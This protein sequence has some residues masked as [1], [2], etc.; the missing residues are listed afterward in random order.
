M[1]LVTKI[2][3][4]LL[5]LL[6]S[7]NQ[8]AQKQ[9]NYKNEKQLLK[10]WQLK[11]TVLEKGNGSE[12]SSGTYSK[13]KWFTAEVPTTVLGALVKNKVYPNP[14]L[15]VNNYLIPDI[16][17]QFNEEHDLAKYSYLPGNVNPWKD[18]YWF[19]TEFLVP[20]ENAGKQVWLNFDGINYR[21]EVWLNGKLVADKEEMAGTFR[22][23]KFNITDKVKSGIKNILAVKIYPVG[24]PGKPGTQFKVFGGNRGP[25]Q[26]LFKDV[27]LKISGGWDCALPVRDRN[28]GIYQDVYLTYTEEVDIIN[29]YIIT[30]LLL[31]D[32]TTADLTIRTTLYNTSDKI[33]KGSLKGKINLLTEIDMVHYVKKVD[34][35][36]DEISFE[37][38]VVVPANDTVTVTLSFND[39]KQLVIKNPH[40]W[41]PNGYGE[42]YLHNLELTFN[43]DGKVSSKKNTLFG[44][45]EITNTFKE[46]DGDYGRIF[47]I[48]GKK[49]F[50]K[51]GWVQPDMLLDM[52]KERVYNEARLLAKANMTIV[53]T[54]DM[55]SPPEEVM[56]AYDKYGLMWWEVFYQCWTTVPGTNSA[57]YPLDHLLA[58]KSQRDIILRYRN[59]PSLTAWIAENE[60]VPGPDLYFALKDDLKRMDNTRPFVASTSI[61]WDWRKHTTYIKDDLPLGMTDSGK[62]GYAWRYPAYYFEVMNNEKGQMFRNELGQPSLPTLS[63]MKKMIFNLGKNKDLEF[64]PL[65]SVWAEHG[66]WDNYGYAYKNYDT[67]IRKIYGY[68][69]KNVDEYVRIAQMVNYDGYRAMFEAANSRMWDITSGIMLWKLNSQYPDIMWLIYDWFLNPTSAYYASKRAC[70]TLHIQMSA[71]DKMVSVINANFNSHKNL[72]VKAAVYDFNLKERWSREEEIN[73]AENRYDEI[74]KVPQPADLTA[75]YFVKL[76]LRDAKDNLISENVYWESSKTPT[77]LSDLGKLENGKTDMNYKVSETESEYVFTVK[78]KNP[79]KKLSFMNRLAVINKANDEEVLPTFWNNNF[80]TLFPGEARTIEARVTKN[81]LKKNDLEVIVDNNR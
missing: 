24:H 45:R 14:R 1:K 43:Y 11:S 75:V 47:H 29:P 50:C 13:D 36:M 40:L 69:S 48:N 76:E 30:D 33:I 59:N 39:F 67:A 20:A 17:D 27:T 79:T 35:R 49:V 57:Y 22:R 56:E 41:W 66:A 60:N 28:T 73:I 18:P 34:A 63:S 10:S 6:S 46:L 70:E 55:P 52:N 5:I 51:G 25:A 53:S 3:L 72:K 42:Q 71:H 31:P 7:V 32:T 21:A 15:D 26:D 80:I 65:D 78:I 77:N 61:L 9:N 12:I 16:S 68:N 4:S 74:F 19:K 58:I 44:I 23:F 54:E 81:E 64:Y 2:V 38:E 62:P 37:K 8:Y